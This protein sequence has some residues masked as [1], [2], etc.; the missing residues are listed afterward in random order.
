[1]TMQAVPEQAPEPPVLRNKPRPR[2]GKAKSVTSTDM[3]AE[4]RAAAALSQTKT[5]RS[6]TDAAMPAAAKETCH[7]AS[8]HE[9]RDDTNR[10]GTSCGQQ[11]VREKLKAVGKTC[12]REL[13][14][15]SNNRND[16]GNR[17]RGKRD[18]HLEPAN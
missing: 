4:S 16:H 2:T 9:E 3:N 17:Q 7:R 15:K 6:T 11:R 13:V 5:R 8:A 14:G 18:K 1:M 12:T 10:R